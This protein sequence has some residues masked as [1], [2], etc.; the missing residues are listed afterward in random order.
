[1]E[2]ELYP[3]EAATR[4]DGLFESSLR[5][6]HQFYDTLARLAA[7]VGADRVGTPRC[8]D[9]LRPDAVTLVAPPAS[10]AEYQPPPRP[11]L[12]GPVLRRIRPVQP[13]VVELS[14][15]HPTFVVCA[16]L[17]VHGLVLHAHGPWRR[18]GNWWDR[19]AWALD[20]WDVQLEKGG[21]Y[22]LG[23]AREGWFVEGIY[24]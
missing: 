3:G 2:L 12:V 14:G 17:A 16:P 6:P 20:E 7:V 19:D 23:H 15:A 1:L 5:D 22:R 8:N 18:S 4:Q 11:A 13:A 24:D 10:I 21:L 9:S